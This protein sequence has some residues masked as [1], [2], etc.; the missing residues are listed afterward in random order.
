MAEPAQRSAASV[1]EPARPYEVDPALPY[2]ADF[3]FP[4]DPPSETQRPCSSCLPPCESE[5]FSFFPH[6]SPLAGC[7]W[8]SWRFRGQCPRQSAALARRIAGPRGRTARR[9]AA[10]RPIASASG[11]SIITCCIRRLNRFVEII[12]QLEEDDTE[13]ERE[14]PGLVPAVERRREE[15]GRRRERERD[16]DR[17]LGREEWRTGGDNKGCPR[18]ATAARRAA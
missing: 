1:V 17:G 8:T 18:A 3:D 10:P 15:S 11:N 7:K 4:R 6:F 13:C 5:M 14:G 16:G 9:A 12:R 2:P